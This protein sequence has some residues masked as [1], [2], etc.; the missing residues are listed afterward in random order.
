MCPMA[1]LVEP[2]ISDECLPL[3]LCWPAR[4]AGPSTCYVV[5][6]SFA[7]GAMA[8]CVIYQYIM[9][10]FNKRFIVF[11]IKNSVQVI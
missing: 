6:A 3:Y 11:L 5:K 1:K 8:V 4:S 7:T 10:K 9:L 2:Y